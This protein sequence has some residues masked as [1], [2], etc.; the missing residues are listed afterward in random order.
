MDTGTLFATVPVHDALYTNLRSTVTDFSGNAITRVLAGLHWNAFGTGA[1]HALATLVIRTA[2]DAMPDDIIADRMCRI[3]FTVG[4]LVA[5]SL[6]DTFPV[7]T[8]VGRR[9]IPIKEAFNAA[10]CG[11]ANSLIAT[12]AII[13]SAAAFIRRWS[14]TLIAPGTRCLVFVFGDRSLSAI[15][16]IRICG[17]FGTAAECTQRG[18]DTELDDSLTR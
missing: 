10:T 15:R 17:G 5:K 18:D 9:A 12:N 1:A 2:G 8:A 13:V 11:I 7:L 3:F 14:L 4:R 6:G 16:A